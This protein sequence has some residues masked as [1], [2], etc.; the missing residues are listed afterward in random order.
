MQQ[1]HIDAF[2]WSVTDEG[3]INW[4]DWQGRIHKN[5]S[6]IRWEKPVHE[7]MTGYSEHTTFPAEEQFAITHKKPIDR[8]IKQNEKY[9]KIMTE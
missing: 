5:R 6:N 7:M 2:K 9:W 4:P 3:W 1:Q 8:Q